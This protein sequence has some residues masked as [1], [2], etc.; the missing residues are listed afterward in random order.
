MEQYRD[1]ESIKAYEEMLQHGIGSNTALRWI[2]KMSRDNARTPMQ[3]TAG[4]QAG[5]TGGTPWIEIN[6]DYKMLNAEAQRK[7]EVSVL[8]YYKKLIALKAKYEALVYGAFEDIDCP[9]SALVG[10]RRLY[11][12]QQFTIWCNPSA[13]EVRVPD[14]MASLGDP[15]LSN[16]DDLGGKVMRPYEARI[17][18]KTTGSEE[19]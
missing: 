8:C 15:L 11:K 4:R 16:M 6:Q 13:G 5:F 7:D 12:G 1:I 17:Y 14:D 9:D 2:G 18:L 3:W 10:Y 19:G